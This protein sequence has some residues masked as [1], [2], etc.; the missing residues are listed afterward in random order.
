MEWTGHS[1]LRDIE[2]KD[3]DHVTEEQ[4]HVTEEQSKRRAR[5]ARQVWVKCGTKTKPLEFNDETPE[6]M[7]RKVRRL[8]N[9]NSFRKG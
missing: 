7:E 3:R 9:A 1:G 5:M 4:D 2:S 8:V 6:K